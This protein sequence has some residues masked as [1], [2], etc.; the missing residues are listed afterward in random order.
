MDGRASNLTQEPRYDREMSKKD[1]KIPKLRATASY[2]SSLR[3]YLLQRRGPKGMTLWENMVTREGPRH[4]SPEFQYK[5]QRPSQVE[6]RETREVWRAQERRRRCEGTRRDRTSKGAS[7][8]I[9]QHWHSSAKALIARRA[10]QKGTMYP[11][12]TIL[13]DAVGVL[14]VF[15]KREARADAPLGNGNIPTSK[16]PRGLH[17]TRT[18]ISRRTGIGLGPRWTSLP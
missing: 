12:S 16:V 4:Q 10:P 13:G 1:E 7:R 18:T 3:A 11:V 8:Q 6:G 9:W 17:L 5:R 14:S 15:R 2:L